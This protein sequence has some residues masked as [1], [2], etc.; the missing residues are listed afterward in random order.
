M[1][2]LPMTI[3]FISIII[4]NVKQMI[5]TISIADRVWKICTSS[6][7]PASTASQQAQ[8]TKKPLKV[9]FNYSFQLLFNVSFLLLLISLRKN[10]LAYL[11]L[12]I[13]CNCSNVWLSGRALIT[14]IFVTVKKWFTAS[15]YDAVT[16]KNPTW[17]S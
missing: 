15:F 4:Q 2:Y 11:T 8:P 10:N 12:I 13:R 7:Q 17:V 1:I 9:H 3:T 6:L 16:T 14:W 5:F